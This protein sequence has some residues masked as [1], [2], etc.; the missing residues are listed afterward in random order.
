MALKETTGEVGLKN[1]YIALFSGPL[2]RFVDFGFLSQ[3]QF[4]P[5][6]MDQIREIDWRYEIT[7]WQLHAHALSFYGVI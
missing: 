3:Q 6:V 7:N 1:A 2:R 5:T 4:R